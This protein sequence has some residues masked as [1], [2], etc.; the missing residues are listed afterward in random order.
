ME[1][2]SSRVPRWAGRLGGSRGRIRRQGIEVEQVNRGPA[3]L[4]VEPDGGGGA[5]PVLGVEPADDAAVRVVADAVQ[6]GLTEAAADLFLLHALLDL[7][8][9]F[10]G[11]V[12]PGLGL[13]EL[14]AEA[15]IAG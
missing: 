12:T 9:G 7:V 4:L 10:P 3:A 8:E 11:D 1:A 14:L 13:G 5:A 6:V 2:K 15:W